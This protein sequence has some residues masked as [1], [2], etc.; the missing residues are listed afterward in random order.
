MS[1]WCWWR[2]RT[3]LGFT[4]LIAVHT[5]TET[6]ELRVTGCPI[7]SLTA[8]DQCL[9]RIIHCFRLLQCYCWRAGC[10]L[11]IGP[12]DSDTRNRNSWLLIN[13]AKFRHVKIECYWFQRCERHYWNSCCNAVSVPKGINHIFVN[14]C[15][16]VLQNCRVYSSAGFF[17]T[18][19]KVVGKLRIYIKPKKFSRCNPTG[20][21]V[22]KLRDQVCPQQY[23]VAIS[24]WLKVSGMLKDRGEL[25][26]SSKH[27]TQNF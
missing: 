11:P 13:F 25:C 6:C 17:V 12:H 10:E 1:V 16:R 22:E 3:P 20:F 2:W 8:F 9:S 14:N 5:P 18:D 24:S 19:C 4:S 23:T 7:P 15:W 27:I 26:N 21:H